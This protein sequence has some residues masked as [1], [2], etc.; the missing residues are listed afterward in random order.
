M[1]SKCL[2]K[3]CFQRVFPSSFESF[4][5][6]NQSGLRLKFEPEAGLVSRCSGS[7]EPY[8][9]SGECPLGTAQYTRLFQHKL[10]FQFYSTTQQRKCNR[11]KDFH[12]IKEFQRGSLRATNSQLNELKACAI[13]DKT[14]SGGP[15]LATNEIDFNLAVTQREHYC[16]TLS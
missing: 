16:N 2:T 4:V 15:S 12:P 14:L 3:Q 11:H 10:T 7:C 8:P 1:L 9:G 5:E 13:N 6:P